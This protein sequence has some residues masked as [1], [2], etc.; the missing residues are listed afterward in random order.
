MNITRESNINKAERWARYKYNL[1][2][3]LGENGERLTSSKEHIDLSRRTATEGMVLL[4]NNG[5][6]P[7][8]E[9]TTVA[10]FGIGSLDYVPGGGGSGRVYSEYVRNIYEGFMCK[11]LNISW[12][13]LF[14][15]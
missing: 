15:K 12:F 13:L 3:N 7:L 11:K 14:K 9:G 6:L 5:T 2:T 4:E 8:K 1:T 10:L